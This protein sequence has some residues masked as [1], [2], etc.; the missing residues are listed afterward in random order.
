MKLLLL[1][2]QNRVLQRFLAQNMKLLLVHAQNRVLQRLVSQNMKLLLVHALTRVLQRLVPQNMKLLLGSRPGQSSTAFG[3][4]EHE[5]LA[6]FLPGQGSPAFDGAQYGLVEL[7]I[8][9]TFLLLCLLMERAVV[10]MAWQSSDPCVSACTSVLACASRG[11]SARLHMHGK[12]SI[13][14]L[15]SGACRRGL[16]RQPRA[17]Y[18]YWQSR[19]VARCGRPCDHALQVPAVLADLQWKVP[20]IPF[21]GGVLASSVAAQ[22][23]GSQCKL[24]SYSEIPQRSSWV[25][26]R[27]ARWCESDRA[28]VRQWRK[29]WFRSCIPLTSGRCPR[30]AGRADS[31]VQVWWRQSSPTVA[32]CRENR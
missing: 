13:L 1:H 29:L 3:A 30:C 18:K 24:Y 22:R 28:L 12:S 9:I 21:I 26:R 27:H 2:A 25:G 20:L 5:T 17:V 14:T 10:L 31:Q 11:T 7:N 8:F 16:H 32:A 19:G 15:L 4:A 23:Q 6:G